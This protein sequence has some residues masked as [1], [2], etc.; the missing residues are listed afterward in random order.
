MK[1][2]VLII[3][4]FIPFLMF[5]QNGI[6]EQL[7]TIE[8]AIEPNSMDGFTKQEVDLDNDGDLDYIYLYQCAE[9]KCLEVYLNVNQNLEKVLFE[10]CYDY[11]LYHN[12]VQKELK[13]K[14]NHCCGESPF[15]SVRSFKFNKDQFSINE[16]YVIFNDSYELI[17]PDSFM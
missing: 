14:L 8:K 9:P 11:N 10:F 7:K 1:T 15:T 3:Y 12:D 4:L 17:E 2:P 6:S 13:V 5:S 16:N